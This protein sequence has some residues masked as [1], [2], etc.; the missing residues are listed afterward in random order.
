MHTTFIDIEL[1]RIDVDKITRTKK[2]IYVPYVLTE[3]PPKEWKDYFLRRIN[4]KPFEYFG[5][6]KHTL[7]L[8]RRTTK[9]EG[10]TVLLECDLDKATV[11]GICWEIVAAHVDDANKYYHKVVE[12]QRRQQLAAETALEKEVQLQKELENFKTD[13][14]K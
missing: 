7:T 14:D 10:N 11:K 12:H 1:E 2:G 5:P 4:G 6:V 13:F 3:T 9:I 8:P